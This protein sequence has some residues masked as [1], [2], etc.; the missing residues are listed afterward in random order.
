MLV[1]VVMLNI[2]FDSW[3]FWMV[4]LLFFLIGRECFDFKFR[5]W[6][7][8]REIFFNELLMFVDLEIVMFLVVKVKEVYG[9]GR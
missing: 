3:V 2:I 1:V 5:G 9:D 7:G 6:C 4:L 8:I